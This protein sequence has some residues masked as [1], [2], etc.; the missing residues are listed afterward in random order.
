MKKVL[1]R[2]FEFSGFSHNFNFECINYMSDSL[3]SQKIVLISQKTR[4]EI[5]SIAISVVFVE[6]KGSIAPR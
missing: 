5:G 6:E 2:N 3:N 4:D 1:S